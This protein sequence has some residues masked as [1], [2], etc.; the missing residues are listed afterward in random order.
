MTEEGVEAIVNKWYLEAAA[1][2]CNRTDRGLHPLQPCDDIGVLLYGVYGVYGVR[3]TAT[4]APSL[5][6]H[7]LPPRCQRDRPRLLQF[8]NNG[9]RVEAG[10]LIV[11][12]AAT[13]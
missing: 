3:V 7:R 13:V 6:L 11:D 8:P 12:A 5:L 9:L 4:R 2:G 10:A 1:S